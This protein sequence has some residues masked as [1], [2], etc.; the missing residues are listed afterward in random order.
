MD[1]TTNLPRKSTRFSILA[2]AVFVTLLALQ[3]GY[4]EQSPA[5]PDVAVETETT[6]I[7]VNPSY[8]PFS[9]IAV[10][11]NVGLY[12]IGV[13]AVTPISRRTNLRVDGNFMNYTLNLTEDNVA[14]SASLSSREFRA[15]YDFYPFHGS[16]RISGG[17]ALYNNFNIKGSATLNSSNSIS[18][19]STDYY[20]SATNP[21]TAN[22]SLV[23]GNK[24]AP[25]FSF[26][27]GNAIP[28]SGRHFAF[29]VEIGA[30]YTGTAQFAL[31]ATG[32]GCEGPCSASNPG[33]PISSVPGFQSNLNTQIAKIKS[34]LAPAKFYPIL[35]MGM[36]YRF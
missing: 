14:Y 3:P 32:N 12:G 31:S 6:P 35:N 2:V 18:L 1:C 13:E 11:V 20:G 26:G 10:G 33:M 8:G 15:T 30:A 9:K 4:S 34:D 21:L 36:T 5:T 27:W 29:P 25:T 28:R 7:A 19:N 16:F 23:Y 22:A 17:A 24:V